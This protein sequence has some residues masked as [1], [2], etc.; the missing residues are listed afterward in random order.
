MRPH[1]SGIERGG[2]LKARRLW[3]PGSSL[4]TGEFSLFRLLPKVSGANVRWTEHKSFLF[5]HSKILELTRSCV[6]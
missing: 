4:T 1:V 6:T 3:E 5:F 2:F